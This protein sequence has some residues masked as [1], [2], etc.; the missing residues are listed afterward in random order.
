M[1]RCPQCGKSYSD[2]SLNFCL[3]DGAR[4]ASPISDH[5]A[6]TIAMGQPQMTAPQNAGRQTDTPAAWNIPQQHIQPQKR[7][8]RNWIWV[9]LILGLVVVLCGGGIGGL[10]LAGKYY[11]PTQAPAK[12]KPTPES[13]PPLAENDKPAPSSDLNVTMANYNKLKV[14]MSRTDVEDILGGKSEEVSSISGGGHT[15]TVNSWEGEDFRSIILTFD[16]DKLTTKTQAG[17]DH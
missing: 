10:F 2:E 12:A 15:Y 17:L 9:T 11:S 16:N 1:K 3:D 14:G 5:A 13:T 8:S 6:E 7:S 4:L